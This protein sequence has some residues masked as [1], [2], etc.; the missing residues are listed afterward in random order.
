MR[1]KVA[2]TQVLDKHQMRCPRC[3]C[4]EAVVV[5][6]A[7]FEVLWQCVDCEWRWPA[8]DEESAAL[9]SFAPKLIH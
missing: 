9:L 2:I 8:S 7:K 1:R 6:D 4:P 3:A 5:L